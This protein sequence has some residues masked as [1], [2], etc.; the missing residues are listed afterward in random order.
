VNETKTVAQVVG[1]N[2]RKFR[3][4]HGLTL[5]QVSRSTR[6]HGLKWSTG[7]VADMENGAISPTIPTLVALAA[8]L[9]ELA[10]A[11][12]L[13]P[14]DA[15]TMHDLLAT[16]QWVEITPTIRLKGSAFARI[17]GGGSAGITLDDSR[18]DAEISAFA[19][20]I[21]S[22]VK[23]DMANAAPGVRIGDVRQA[24]AGTGLADERAA[25][26]L[27][28]SVWA[29][30][31]WAV[32]LWGHSL[33]AERDRVLGEGASPQKRGRLTRELVE[34]IEEAVRRGND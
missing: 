8:A 30:T 10:G 6:T 19:A 7:R 27:G 32:K 2:A 3:K 23:A 31:S 4:E 21:S 14:D 18:T 9:E 13:S 16:D 15:V 33:T 34:Q 20:G 1:E 24:M 26:R 22:R 17:I 5:E 12:P 11:Y 28:L 25:R 29:V